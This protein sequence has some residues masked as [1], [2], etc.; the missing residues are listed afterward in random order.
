MMGKWELISSFLSAVS[1]L[2]KFIKKILVL[3]SYHMLLSC[4][5]FFLRVGICSV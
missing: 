1:V 5:Y 4:L 2:S 3:E